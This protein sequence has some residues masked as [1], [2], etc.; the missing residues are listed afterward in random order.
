MRVLITAGPTIEKIDPVRYISNFSTGKMGIALAEAAAEQGHQ[1]TLVLG[2]THLRP[3]NEVVDV[4]P[5]E[6]ALD[7]LAAAEA[8][9]AEADLIILC[10]A[11]ADYR[12]K[13]YEEEK[14]KR[15]YKD[16]LT[17]ELV[18]NPD[19]AATLGA[20]KQAGQYMIGFALET[21]DQAGTREHALSKMQRKHLDMIV[22]NTLQDAGAGFGYDTNRVC[23]IYADGREEQL[24]L[25]SK[26][27]VAR[28]ILQ[29]VPVVHP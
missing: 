9:F 11:V 2:P 17:L 28:R 14:I 6:S 7:M 25:L 12:P 13:H 27:E 24:P 5:V 15:E 4:L 22:S 29:Q 18:K 21:S 23:L 10:A 3:K 8:H 1:V 20:K 16:S 26:V 19:I